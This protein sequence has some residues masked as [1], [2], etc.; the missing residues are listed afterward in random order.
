MG[1]FLVFVVLALF[2]SAASA[3]NI[4]V[5]SVPFYGHFMPL[6]AVAERLVAR[7]HTVTVVVEDATWCDGPIPLKCE[8]VPKSGSYS[9]ELFQRVSDMEDLVLTWQP[10]VE[11]HDNHHKT[12]L[13]NFLDV[14]GSKVLRVDPT[15]GKPTVHVDAILMDATTLV[16][17][18]VAAKYDLP[19]VA[20]NPI[21]QR[22][23]PVSDLWLP[24][25]G[26][27]HP[28]HQ[29]Y[30]QRLVNAIISLVIPYIAHNIFI[31]KADIVRENSGLR[32]FRSMAEA[33]GI[34]TLLL[35]PTIWGYDIPQAI[36]PNMVPLGLLIPEHDDFPMEDDL[37]SFLA[38]DHCKVAGA[39]YVNFG[40]LAMPGDVLIEKLLKVF[41]E[42]SKVCV[43]WKIKDDTK[44]LKVLDR[45][46]AASVEKR[47]YMT[48]RFASP[49]AIMRHDAVGA[50]ITHCGDTSLGEAIHS[51]VPTIGLPFFADQGDV[52]MRLDECGIG[53]CL[54]HKH[55]FT[56]EL[57]ITAID[58]IWANRTFTE[59]REN[60]VDRST[61]LRS[62]QRVRQMANY[63]GGAERGA[64][65]V[66]AFVGKKVLRA[67][68]PFPL[69]PVYFGMPLFWR[70]IQF[71]Y[72][73]A[74]ASWTVVSLFGITLVTKVLRKVFTSAA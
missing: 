20:V 68:E 66:E 27:T 34:D 52:C 73:P 50:F 10:I 38:S 55:R 18:G 72:G 51:N 2:V 16:G 70:W 22:S 61:F 29:S 32:H 54:G 63:S 23:A 44:R 45:V 57:L 67:N 28:R 40:T 26:T 36:P 5:I 4:V 46:K 62:L 65:L 6:K 31:V 9:A 41:I 13:G 56:E 33:G 64:E 53:K 3:L 7:G 74:V 25:L 48:K 1:R 30:P 11:E 59:P 17:Y 71:Q 43:V 47:F 12:Q 37:A 24:H 14:V 15:S 60:Q 58:A 19:V 49:V 69:T 8:T 21:L 42:K 35:S 39:L